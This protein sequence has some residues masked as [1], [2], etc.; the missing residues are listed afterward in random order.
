MLEKHA[1]YLEGVVKQPQQGD[2][3]VR[4]D[5]PEAVS[6]F[7]ERLREATELLT[8]A[9][10]CGRTEYTIPKKSMCHII[11]C[12]SSTGKPQ[13]QKDSRRFCRSLRA[14][15]ER[16]PPA[17]ATTVEGRSWVFSYYVCNTCE[18]RLVGLT[19]TSHGIAAQ[20]KRG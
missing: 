6:A 14:I 4:W 13:A 18:P 7:I 5:S 8:K 1:R 15:D 3:A 10:C 2:R 17:P 20:A 16:R 9:S 19:D 12:V 11:S